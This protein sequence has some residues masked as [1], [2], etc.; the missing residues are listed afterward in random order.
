M[1]NDILQL[2]NTQV[3][4]D[5][6]AACI[7]DENIYSAVRHLVSEDMFADAESRKLFSI[8]VQI[9]K[10]GKIPY[11]A[12]VAMRFISS[13]G[14]VNTFISSDH[15]SFS[16]TLQKIELLRSIAMKRN[17]YVLCAKGMSLATDPT[18]GAEDFQKLFSSLSE[19]ASGDEGNIQYFSDTIQTLQNDV[20]DRMNGK[21]E[22][23]IMTGLHVFDVRYGMHQG[24]LVIIAGRTSQGKTT[25]ATTI[26]RNMA[27]D[28]VPAVFYSLEMGSKQ[29]AARILSKDSGIP[30]SRILYDRLTDG[31]YSR[32]YDTS[33][34]MAGLPIYFDEKSKTSFEKICVSIRA[35]V[36]KFGIKIVFVDYLQI[37]VNS[38]QG[39]SREAMLG[40]ITREFKR[41]AVECN[42][43]MVVLSQLSRS[44][45]NTEPVL[46]NLRGSGQ[47]EEAADMVVFVYRPEVYGI[48]RWDDGKPT[49]GTAKII[50]A[51]GRNIGLAKEVVSFDGNL[52]SFSDFSG[53]VILEEK[54]DD[55]PWNK[56]EQGS[57]PF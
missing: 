28:K 41:I 56:T 2:H 53:T 42:V 26:A 7:T 44:Q 36:R 54:Q 6:L 34:V 40:D 43:C 24:D 52:T 47:I 18:A 20:A 39:S 27:F 4:R 57:L 51:K 11:L 49:S 21:E 8:I 46:S 50:I 30:S 35:M 15:F 17:L 25:L 10:E 14:D 23:G 12:E 32:F 3:E 9:E 5:V 45:D 19:T 55:S 37:L 16:V 31:E 33:S 38:A 22:S 13:G 29:L 48:E 1:A